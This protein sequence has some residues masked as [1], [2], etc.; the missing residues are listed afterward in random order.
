M[1]VL[2]LV[3]EIAYLVVILHLIDIIFFAFEKLIAYHPIALKLAQHEGCNRWM[4]K[5]VQPLKAFWRF[6]Q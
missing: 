4:L 3:A 6:G 5:N 2:V 1:H